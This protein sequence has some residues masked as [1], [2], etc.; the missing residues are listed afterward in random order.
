MVAVKSTVQ[1]SAAIDSGGS[2]VSVPP[3]P[4]NHDLFVKPLGGQT[5][6][7]VHASAPMV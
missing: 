4:K 1:W 3:G 5:S 6:V 7:V 2:A